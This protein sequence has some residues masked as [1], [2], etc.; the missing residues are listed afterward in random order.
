VHLMERNTFST[1]KLMSFPESKLVTLS[2]KSKNN[3]TIPSREKVL[4]Y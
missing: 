3:P 2:F 4:T 1:G